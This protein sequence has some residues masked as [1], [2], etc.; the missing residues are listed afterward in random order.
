MNSLEWIS[1]TGI[2]Y[3]GA[4]PTGA[5]MPEELPAGDDSSDE[6][7]NGDSG[8]H[9]HNHVNGNTT[10]GP[11]AH[12]H[13][14][15]FSSLNDDEFYGDADSDE[16]PTN[17]IR[18]IEFLDLN[19][20]DR[21]S[22]RPRCNCDALALTGPVEA[23]EDDGGPIELSKAKMWERWVVNRSVLY[24]CVIHGRR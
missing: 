22:T 24:Q 8:Y 9:S 5:E 13:H 17:D 6:S 16:E 23:L 2:G 4:P 3:A 11:S 7:D 20:S 1:L 18:E 14:A 15:N 12:H 10:S 21:S 19:S